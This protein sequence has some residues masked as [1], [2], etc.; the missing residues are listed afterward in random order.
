[1]LI[2]ILASIA[3]AYIALQFNSL[4]DY[5]Q[6][7]FSVFNAPLFAVLL[8]GTFTTWATPAA[9]FWGLLAGIFASVTHNL[10]F[11]M[12]RLRYGSDMSANFYR[13]IVAWGVCLIV[14][15]TISTFTERKPL[16][17]LIGVTY[18][19]RDRYRSPVPVQSHVL[20]FAIILICILLDIWFR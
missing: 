20:A 11:Q 10:A 9:G 12:H 7:L 19:T 8:L 1:M 4:M 6:L 13:A 17:D 3:T 5:L 2:A 18:Q 15:M 16:K 14:T